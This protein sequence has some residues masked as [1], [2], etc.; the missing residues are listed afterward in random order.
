MKYLLIVCVLFAIVIGAR[1]KKRPAPKTAEPAHVTQVDIARVSQATKNKVLLYFWKPNC[2][3]C[4]EM[5]P[6]VD[7][8]AA[9]YPDIAVIKI[10][11]ADENNRPVHD[12][13]RI[14]ATPSFVILQN[15]KETTR[16]ERPFWDKQA[17]ISFLQPSKIY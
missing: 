7:K 11:T 6:I 13:Y 15:G 10:N 3:G 14:H 5:S 2:P 9:E 12:E 4:L 1:A 17:Y 8:V 16:Y